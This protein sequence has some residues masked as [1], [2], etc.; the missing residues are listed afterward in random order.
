M[1]NAKSSSAL[2]KAKT[3]KSAKIKANKKAPI[4]SGAVAELW[5]KQFPK[6]LKKGMRRVDIIEHLMCEG[7]NYWTVRTQ[8]Q[9]YIAASNA[10]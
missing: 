1:K 3:K 10:R 5:N 4:Q 7:Y 6:L 2:A 9:R 8:L